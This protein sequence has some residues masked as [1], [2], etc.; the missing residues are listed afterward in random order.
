MAASVVA[1]AFDFVLASVS[2][3]SHNERRNTVVNVI[4][5]GFEDEDIGLAKVRVTT[6]LIEKYATNGRTL[7]RNIEQAVRRDFERIPQRRLRIT[8]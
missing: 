1:I 4:R 2:F 8:L 5:Y 6:A 7:A 3:R